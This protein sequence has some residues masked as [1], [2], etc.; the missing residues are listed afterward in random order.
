MNVLKNNK[1]H[2]AENL[3]QGP[4]SKKRTILS[5]K[6]KN[7]LSPFAQFVFALYQNQP[8]YLIFT[9]INDEFEKS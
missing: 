5:K 2:R 3:K 4:F 8:K 9:L 7:I 1:D 6:N